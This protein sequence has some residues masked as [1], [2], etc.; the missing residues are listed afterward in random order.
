MNI[1]NRST[2]QNSEYQ[3]EKS[4]MDTQSKSTTQCSKVRLEQSSSQVA[5][6]NVSLQS[7]DCLTKQKNQSLASLTTEISS[8]TFNVAGIE[9]NYSIQ[10]GKRFINDMPAEDFMK[11]LSIQQLLAIAHVAVIKSK[12]N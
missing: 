11:T 10:N 7:N 2:K 4:L 9:F 6:K 12:L 8:G 5:N 1:D 3:L